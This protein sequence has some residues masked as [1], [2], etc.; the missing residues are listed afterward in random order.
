MPE[1]CYADFPAVCT[2]YAKV[3]FRNS[4]AKIGRCWTD[5]KFQTFAQPEWQAHL[6]LPEQQFEILVI[7]PFK[8]VPCTGQEKW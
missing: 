8:P 3:R 7:Q 1:V 6:A 2:H 4:A 5:Y